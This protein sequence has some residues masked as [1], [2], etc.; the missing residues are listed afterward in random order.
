[1]TR[2]PSLCE[3]LYLF[4]KIALR[5][6]LAR[7]RKKGRGGEGRALSS[8]QIIFDSDVWHNLQLRQP[9]KLVVAVCAEAGTLSLVRTRYVEVRT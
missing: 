3:V 5:S 9:A 7:E 8:L 1:M 4:E 6:S 2:S